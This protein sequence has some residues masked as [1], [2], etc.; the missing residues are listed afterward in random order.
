MTEDQVSKVMQQF[1]G[2]PRTAETEREMAEALA[3]FAPPP[4]AKAIV[5]DASPEKMRSGVVDL[6]VSSN[7]PLNPPQS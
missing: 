7:Y 1:V 5:V 3:T 4:V 2:K 6:V